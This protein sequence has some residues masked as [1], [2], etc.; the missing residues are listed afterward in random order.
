MV[1]E[2]LAQVGLDP[3]RRIDV[4]AQLVALALAVGEQ[5]RLLGQPHLHVGDAPA[6]DLGFGG[7][8]RELALELRRRGAERSAPCRARRRVPCRP[9]RRLPSRARSG[10]RCPS[11]RARGRD[12]ILEI[13]DLRLERDDLDA[14][15][16]GRRGSVRRARR[17]A[18]ASS[19]S[20][21][22][23]VALGLAQ[24]AGLDRELVLGRAQLILDALVARFEREDGRG[25]FA[26]LDLEPVDDVGLLAEFGELA[27]A[28]WSSSA[29]RSFRA[30]ASTSRTRRAADPCRPGFPPSTAA[31]RLRAGAWSGAPRGRAR[32]AR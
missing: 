19:A 20:L 24:R 18:L 1:R 9:S 6:Q 2:L 30:A 25:L 13:V 32:A 17:V 31:S 21:S 11:P 14:L 16:V 26:E 5:A 3:A 27:G 23:S 10:P 28:S 29:R 7:L 4:G 12:L 8:R 22:A 15:A